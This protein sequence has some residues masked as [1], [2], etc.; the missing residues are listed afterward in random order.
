MHKP[1]N[2]YHYFE[3]DWVQRAHLQYLTGK[4]FSVAISDR[5]Q[6]EHHRHF[7]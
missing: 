2:G 6:R 5:H 1:G 4:Q 7:H 3:N